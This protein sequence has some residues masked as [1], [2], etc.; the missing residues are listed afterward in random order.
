MNQQTK[1]DM[2]KP[3]VDFAARDKLRHDFLLAQGMADEKIVPLASDASFRRYFRL[4]DK[5]WRGKNLLVMDS[6]PDLYPTI[7]FEKVADLLTPLRT[8]KIATITARDHDNGFLLLEDLGAD[9]LTRLLA[10]DEAQEEELYTKV[11]AGLVRSQLAWHEHYGVPPPKHNG[12]LP[13]YDAAALTREAILL[14]QWYVPEKNQVMPDDASIE[15][16]VQLLQEIYHQLA[17][18]CAP[19]FDVFVHRDFHVD[20]LLL[21]DDAIAWLDFQDGLLGHPTYDVMSLLEDARR[22]ITPAVKK[23]LWQYFIGAWQAKCPTHKNLADDFLRWFYF[24]GLTRHAKVL[25]IFVRL[26]KRDGKNNYHQHLPRVLKLFRGSMSG[27]LA[28]TAQTDNVNNQLA[29]A[30]KK[31]QNLL[32]QW[33]LL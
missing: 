1:P 13:A 22:D 8:M 4:V 11:I 3:A 32:Q 26:E 24:L 12:L 5:K 16:F 2:K 10:A 15:Q 31:L 25:G 33:Q 7:I 19:P 28:A 6:P 23:I 9:S 30:V 18:T 14:P 21:V 27:L 29:G 17:T 20:N